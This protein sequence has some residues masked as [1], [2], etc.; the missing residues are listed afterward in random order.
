ML[1]NPYLQLP[2]P[3]EHAQIYSQKR[4]NSGTSKNWNS[5]SDCCLIHNH[6]PATP[7]TKYKYF[8]KPRFQ[9]GNLTRSITGTMHCTQPLQCQLCS[10]MQSASA[11]CIV[12]RIAGC[13]F[14]L[15]RLLTRAPAAKSP[16][17]S[18]PPAP[19]SS[20]PPPPSLTPHHQKSFTT[21]VIQHQ[22]SSS[23]SLV[24]QV[25]K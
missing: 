7:T 8:T 5:S 14:E 18:S 17:P 9:V 20:P 25:I 6:Q 24:T 2:P 4:E 10:I 19:P 13:Q 16:L 23:S 15:R 11:K 3:V 21:T 1:L 12:G 22:H